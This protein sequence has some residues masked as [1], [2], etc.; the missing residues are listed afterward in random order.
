MVNII[1]MTEISEYRF[2]LKKR[3]ESCIARYIGL[4]EY[5]EIPDMDLWLE[6]KEEIINN[7]ITKKNEIIQDSSCQD[8][9]DVYDFYEDDYYDSQEERMNSRADKFLCDRHFDRYDR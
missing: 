2:M 7:P 5:M 6:L 9:D 3:L 4:E 1:N 8:N